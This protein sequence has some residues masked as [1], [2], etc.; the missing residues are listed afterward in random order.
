MKIS[1]CFIAKNEEKNIVRAL[2]SIKNQVD[3]LILVDTGS[4]DSTVDIFRSYGGIVYCQPWNNDFSS[5]RNLSLSYATGDW[6]ILLDA[7]EYFSSDTANNLRKIIEENAKQDAL[8]INITNINLENGAVKDSFYN[9][10]A[11]RNQQGIG[12]S[13]KIHEQLMFNGKLFSK[14]KAIDKAESNIFH[15]GYSDVLLEDKARRNLAILLSEI[16]DGRSESECYTYLAECYDSMGDMKN[17]LKYAKLDVAQGRRSVSY[18]SRSYRKLMKYY[19]ANNDLEQR[20]SIVK[21]AVNDFPEL[22]EFHGELSICYYQQQLYDEAILEL[23]KAIELYENYNGIEPCLLDDGDLKKMKDNLLLLKKKNSEISISACLICKNEAENIQLWIDNVKVFADEMIIVDTGS[24][25]ETVQIIEENNIKCLHYN[26]TG[27]FADA[28]NYAI[29]NASKDWIVFTDSDEFFYQPQLIKGCLK[30]IISQNKNIDA[31]MVPISN[32]DETL[33]DIE[34]SRFNGLRMFKRKDNIRYFG[35]IHEALSD[36]KTIGDVRSLNVAV[37]DV[38]LLVRHTGYSNNKIKAKLYRNKELLQQDIEKNG[39]QEKHY[40]YLAEN[41]YGLGNYTQALKYSFL[42]IDSS[43]QAV[44]Q[45]GDMYWLA[46]NSLEELHYSR[47]ERGALLKQAIAVCPDIPDFYGLYGLMLM[48]D[49]AELASKYLKNALNVF[50]EMDS[51]SSTNFQQIADR[52]YAGLGRYYIKQ[53]DGEM[54]LEYFIGALKINKWQ[55]EA[56]IGLA[57]L[58]DCEPQYELLKLLDEIFDYHNY[59]QVRNILANIFDNNGAVE[60]AKVFDTREKYYYNLLREEKFD[61]MMQKLPADM[62]YS[63]QMVFIGLLNVELDLTNYLI[64]KQLESLPG[65]LRQLILAYHIEDERIKL[66]DGMF[67]E[68][69]SMLTIIMLQPNQAIK[70]CYLEL[71]AHFSEEAITKVIEVAVEYELWNLGLYLCQQI[72]ADSDAVTGRF[73]FNAGKCLYNLNNPSAAG[74]CFERSINLLTDDSRNE[75]VSYL[76]WCQEALA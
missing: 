31:V 15:T 13:G 56:I 65:N 10:R 34:I 74:E 6:I 63:M 26:W 47:E 14:I 3:E 36:I 69:N 30:E 16:A 38:R 73:W 64:K 60:L 7:D 48:E 21:K 33:H 46:A 42:A 32:V 11:V 53:G 20:Y 2:E 39:L 24:E 67:D 72:S 51:I 57:D 5:P 59:L 49:N 37:A 19:A 8:M 58:Y 43:V 66:T 12:Y 29:E 68:Y 18:A 44:G 45:I 17:M 41:Y 50:K 75:A 1:A 76:S 54:S 70:E 4:T 35:K 40:R 52:V 28:K 22:P 25:D 23:E 55:E 61:E 27:S 71:A 62:V 9:L